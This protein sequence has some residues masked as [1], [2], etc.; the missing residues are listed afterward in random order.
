MAEKQF[1]M[2]D[3][4]VGANKRKWASTTAQ[5][6]VFA[7]L[8]KIITILFFRSFF[9]DASRNNQQRTEMQQTAVAVHRHQ[10]HQHKNRSH[11]RRRSNGNC[12]WIKPTYVRMHGTMRRYH[13]NVPKNLLKRMATF[14]C[15]TVSHSQAITCW[16]AWQRDP[17][18]ILS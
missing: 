18:Y 16:L 13:G 11:W 17:F 12:R 2:K 14:S 1:K 8:W 6:I 4:F 10:S 3:A 15:E 9:N 5:H 7:F